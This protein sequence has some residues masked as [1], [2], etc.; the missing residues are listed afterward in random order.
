MI[1]NRKTK[2]QGIQ[3]QGSSWKSNL[4][5][6]T[7]QDLSQIVLN[8]TKIYPGV[9]PYLRQKCQSHAPKAPKSAGKLTPNKDFMDRFQSVNRKYQELK[10]GI[11]S[12]NFASRESFE[13][14]Q[15]KKKVFINFKDNIRKLL[16][17]EA[18]KIKENIRIE[19]EQKK[20]NFEN[21]EK[22]K[23]LSVEKKSVEI[24]NLEEKVKILE[25]SEFELK[26]KIQNLI[27]ELNKKEP[28]IILKDVEKLH[29]LAESIP[30][31]TEEQIE[32]LRTEN[33]T[34]STKYSILTKQKI[35]FK[36]KVTIAKTRFIEVENLLREA[37][38]QAKI[39]K[40]KFEDFREL[41]H[42]SEQKTQIEIIKIEKFTSW[43]H[44]INRD[45]TKL[46]LP[47]LNFEVE[48]EPLIE[49]FNSKVKKIQEIQIEVDRMKILFEQQ[50]KEIEENLKEKENRENQKEGIEEKKQQID[51][52]LGKISHLE[53]E[54]SGL[55]EANKNVKSELERKTERVQSLE[56]D[57]RMSKLKLGA[58]LKK[59]QN[60]ETE[61]EKLKTQLNLLKVEFE[62]RE[63]EE[64]IILI[65]D[66]E[67]LKKNLDELKIKIE[68]L[69]SKNKDFET[70]IEDLTQLKTNQEN[71]IKSLEEEIQNLEDLQRENEQ[72]SQEDE[73]VIEVLRENVK[74]LTEENDNLK[75]EKDNMNGQIEAL[76]EEIKFLKEEAKESEENSPKKLMGV[77][78][79]E[80]KYNDLQDEYEFMKSNFEEMETE[81]EEK[82]NKNDELEAK[83]K[84]LESI[85]EKSDDEDDDHNLKSVNQLLIKIKEIKHDSSIIR[86]NLEARIST[87]KSENYKYSK[88]NE[89]LA[90][91][92]EKLTIDFNKLSEITNE[93]QNLKEELEKNQQ[94][95]ELL[96]K[97]DKTIAEK[98][99]RLLTGHRGSPII[100]SNS[101][102][103][104][105]KVSTQ[106][107]HLE[108]QNEKLEKTIRS[109]EF[110]SEE[111]LKSFVKK[112]GNKILEVLTEE[113]NPELL[114]LM[115][116]RKGG[117]K[118]DIR[119][120]KKVKMTLE[121]CRDAIKLFRTI[122]EDFMGDL[123][124]VLSEAY[125]DTNEF[126]EIKIVM[127][128]L[129]ERLKDVENVIKESKIETKLEVN[130][131][132]KKESTM[133]K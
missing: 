122:I 102:R 70:Q 38:N 66:N 116:E 94:K 7:Q 74:K 133:L 47:Q 112:K 99:K 79:Y 20:I 46:G 15:V 56:Q 5:E 61:T 86:K 72:E 32:L 90:N 24:Q 87:L 93:N 33:K 11:L 111:E 58:K 92:I 64:K 51:V 98:L 63:N 26:Q 118:V 121:N 106:F 97:K 13:Q 60:F 30:E 82:I 107:D 110:I 83:I 91:E 130:V 36:E 126:K 10:D 19:M 73:T 132:V 128:N 105:E 77:V 41:Q 81:M 12:F 54:N 88:E 55:R 18:E 67:N 80:K 39:F 114:N 50:N 62:E 129:K 1:I 57:E 43:L 131:K 101:E 89:N 109:H 49:I 104:I 115:K 9:T 40:K 103:L 42:N 23:N 29:P 17:S 96:E 35:K 78:D 108:R 14:S 6:I 76:S 3:G 21:F 27:L 31:S 113:R 117:E 68:Q 84:E 125:D 16:D 44:K 2:F 69:Q 123:R 120:L 53:N 75:D 100:D 124:T 45:R 85:I 25:S 28:K 127:R 8:L 95:V 119:V 37:Q 71:R 65:E 34:I 52:L 4:H 48:N 22:T 59:I